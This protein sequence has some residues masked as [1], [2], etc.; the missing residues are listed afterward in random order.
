MEKSPSPCKLNHLP[1]ILLRKATFHIL[2]YF[3]LPLSSIHYGDICSIACIIQ[4]HTTT[5]SWQSCMM[6]TVMHLLL[7]VSITHCSSVTDPQRQYTCYS[8]QCQPPVPKPGF[9]AQA[10]A[11]HPFSS[12][13]PQFNPW[14]Q[15]R[16]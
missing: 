8:L 12:I 4:L 13:H 15:P 16:W 10:V 9:L 14:C 6:D 5:N 7:S 11:V 2:I 3:S 1:S